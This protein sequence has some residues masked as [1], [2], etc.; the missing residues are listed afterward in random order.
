MNFPKR[1][2]FLSYS[3]ID[4]QFAQHLK[5][6][7]EAQKLAVWMD[8][9]D[10]PPGNSW[11]REIKDNIEKCSIFIVIVSSNSHQSFNVR[12]EISHALKR[13]RRI[14]PILIEESSQWDKYVSDKVWKH[15]E[16]IQFE[17]MPNT[18]QAILS[19]SLMAN[20]KNVVEKPFEEIYWTTLKINRISEVFFTM[21]GSAMLIIAL[22]VWIIHPAFLDPL[23]LLCLILSILGATCLGGVATIIANRRM[24]T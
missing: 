15:L 1:F 2:I 12:K 6:L 13:E 8:K 17:L 14:V 5:S 21:F 24:M 19:R 10:I 4:L 11:R 18:M 7:L 20:L 3:R 16:K 9:S 23:Q 22:T